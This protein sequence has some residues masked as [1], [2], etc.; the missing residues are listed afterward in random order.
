MLPKKLC[1][2]L[3]KI[4][5]IIL[6]PTSKTLNK[7]HLEINHNRKLKTNCVNANNFFCA[8]RIGKISINKKTL[9]L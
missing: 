4:K 6:K 5:K 9:H 3:G 2:N 8:F 7:T 1:E